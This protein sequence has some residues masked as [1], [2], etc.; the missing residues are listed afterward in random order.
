MANSLG[1]FSR[2]AFLGLVLIMAL[3]SNAILHEVGHYITADH[4]GLEPRMYLFDNGQGTGFSFV[5]QNFYVTYNKPA[6][7]D[8]SKM[9]LITFAGPAVN[10]LL[11][12]VSTI[13]LCVTPKRKR[14][15]RLALL[16]IATISALSAIFNLIP[17]Q[18]SDGE[19]L[20]KLLK[21]L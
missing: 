4:Y 7:I 2:G 18:G 11:S 16:I 20:L 1:L 21:G 13:A 17:T 8:N 14:L 6:K 19:T 15:T 3:Y 12:I 5:N 9:E 10:I